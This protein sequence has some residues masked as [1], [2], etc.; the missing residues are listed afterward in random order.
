MTSYLEFD[1]EKSRMMPTWLQATPQYKFYTRLVRIAV[2]LFVLFWIVGSLL[3]GASWIGDPA[4]CAVNLPRCACEWA[5]DYSRFVMQPINAWSSLAIAIVG[6]VIL[7]KAEKYLMANSGMQHYLWANINF[8]AGGLVVVILGLS[9]FILHATLLLSGERLAVLALILVTTWFACYSILRLISN[10]HDKD[11]QCINHMT[12]S[13]FYFPSVLFWMVV[14]IVK[15]SWGSGAYLIIAGLIIVTIVCEFYIILNTLLVK[16][17]H[18][19][20]GLLLFFGICFF[21][22]DTWLC[23]PLAFIQLRA[24]AKFFIAAG[25]FYTFQLYLNTCP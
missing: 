22:L 2:I 6:L 9:W 25:L 23:A 4:N 11:V 15:L 21:V 24:C 17:I 7:W 5:N 20:I 18:I 8:F 19:L 12:M 13:F 16:P 10:L 3:D 14:F 1:L